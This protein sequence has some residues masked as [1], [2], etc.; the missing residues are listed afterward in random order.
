[1]M[2]FA[3]YEKFPVRRPE[4]FYV[5]GNIGIACILYVRNARHRP[6]LIGSLRLDG[7]IHPDFQDCSDVL[8]RDGTS[9]EEMAREWQTK[10]PYRMISWVGWPT[11]EPGPVKLE[12]REEKFIRFT[13]R[14]PVMYGRNE[15]AKDISGYF[16]FEDGS[17][18]PK[19]PTTLPVPSLIF[20]GPLHPQLRPEIVSGVVKM[21]V[22]VGTRDV[23]V[24]VTKI[25]RTR[26]TSQEAWSASQR[27]QDLYFDPLMDAV[28]PEPSAKVK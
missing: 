12:A 4:G 22:R 20:Q 8:G 25:R 6:E 16:G 21:T 17:Q 28:V 5:V 18:H 26:R 1:M 9:F 10:K 24:P 7:K 19:L 11:D 13:F 27:P 15:Y 2:P 3:V 23:P 14:E